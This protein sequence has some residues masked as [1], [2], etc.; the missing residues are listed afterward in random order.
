MTRI[1]L[2]AG[3]S[4]RSVC[5][6]VL[7]GGG[8]STEVESTPLHS[9][10]AAI[11]AGGTVFAVAAVEAGAVGLGAAARAGSVSSVANCST[12]SE[13]ARSSVAAG[14]TLG[15]ATREFILSARRADRRAFEFAATIGRRFVSG[16]A[17]FVD[18]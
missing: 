17:I 4:N 1:W 16:R 9:L 13:L 8:S 10:V 15:Q 18:A 12:V 3:A 7:A 6:S 11:F 5:T 2:D 14:S